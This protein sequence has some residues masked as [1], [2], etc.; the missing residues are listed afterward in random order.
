L[1][2]DL[3][4]SAVSDGSGNYQ[5]SSLDPGGSYTVTPTKTALEPGSAGIT[6][7]DVVA[8]QRHFLNISVIPPGCQLVA[9]DVNGDSLITTAD[10]ISVQRFILNNSTG[11]A[12]VGKYRFTPASRT[13]SGLVS[14]QAGQDYSALIFG[15]VASP[16]AE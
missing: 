11:I 3:T 4:T 8:I 1:T 14:N 6:T 16:F 10:I 9:A 2:G 7:V 15:D 5:F 13:Y 12:N